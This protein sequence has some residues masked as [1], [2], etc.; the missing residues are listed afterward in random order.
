[1]KGLEEVDQ[2]ELQAQYLRTEALWS[3]LLE[4]G[5]RNRSQG[6]IEAF[7]FAGDASAAASLI[8]NYV[9]AGWLPLI[10]PIDD[11]SGQIRI[12]LVSSLV[13]LT[14]EAFL[15]LVDVMMISAHKHRC[16]FDGFQVEVSAVQ[17]APPWWRFW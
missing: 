15:E 9:K 12:K 1:M 7:L 2:T 13:C 6:R 11:G 14:R 5:V 17:P 8:A 16:V 4:Q 3:T 10:E